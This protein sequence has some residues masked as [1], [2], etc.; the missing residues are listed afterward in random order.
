M[1]LTPETIELIGKVIYAIGL[2]FVGWFFHV[3]GRRI[4]AEWS[5]FLTALPPEEVD[6]VVVA[7]GTSQGRK[8]YIRELVLKQVN[9]YSVK[10]AGVE[11]TDGQLTTIISKL[12]AFWVA[13]TK[14]AG[15][16]K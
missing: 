2:P 3:L 4:P 14:L 1:K 7:V 16:G 6:K 8:D 11:I 10:V 12:Q 15:S 13:G 9:K 5:A